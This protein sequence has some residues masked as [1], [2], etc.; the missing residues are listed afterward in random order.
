MLASPYRFNGVSVI[1][2]PGLW[3]GALIAEKPLIGRSP[4]KRGAFT[5][6]LLEGETMTKLT[7][8]SGAKDFLRAVFAHR[9]RKTE[10]FVASFRLDTSRNSPGRATQD[11]ARFLSDWKI[12]ADF[13]EI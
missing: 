4:G 7:L 6:T 11:G 9:I 10:L 2:L 3:H 8:I 1:A 13:T 5:L 12:R